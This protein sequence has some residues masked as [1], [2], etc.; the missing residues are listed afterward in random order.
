MKMAMQ[1]S[2]AE[3]GWLM[4]LAWVGLW[5]WLCFEDDVD[6]DCD[7]LP[8]AESVYDWDRWWI[9]IVKYT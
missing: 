3:D 9:C 7:E 5:W 2:M 4:V 8:R 1:W 6:D